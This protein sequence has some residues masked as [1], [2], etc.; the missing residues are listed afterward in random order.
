MLELQ[1]VHAQGQSWKTRWRSF[2]AGLSRRTTMTLWE[3]RSLETITTST[4]AGSHYVREIDTNHKTK[5]QVT[6]SYKTQ[7]FLS[8]FHAFAFACIRVK[9]VSKMIHIFCDEKQR[10]K[11]KSFQPLNHSGT[12]SPGRRRPCWWRRWSRIQRAT[13]TKMMMRRRRKMPATNGMCQL[14]IENY[15]KDIEWSNM[16]W[17]NDSVVEIQILFLFCKLSCVLNLIKPGQRIVLRKHLPP[18][19]CF[20]FHI[21]GEVP[22]EDKKLKLQKDKNGEL[23]KENIARIANAVQVTIWL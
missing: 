19:V 2:S 20:Y 17:L 9:A 8:F 22:G 18:A 14:W 15:K 12:S 1:V 11:R 6:N 13:G 4:S 21:I 23:Q 7:L 10:R 3:L 16:I 5:Y